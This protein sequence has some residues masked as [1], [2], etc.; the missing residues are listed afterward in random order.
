MRSETMNGAP[1][2][3]V[4]KQ[5]V[6]NSYRFRSFIPETHVKSNYPFY[7]AKYSTAEMSV[8]SNI[9]YLYKTYVSYL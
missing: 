9:Y 5:K 8:L 2:V 7:A 4:Q 1:P 3:T 6:L